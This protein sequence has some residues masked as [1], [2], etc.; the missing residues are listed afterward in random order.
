MNTIPCS[1]GCA[2]G[3][4]RYQANSPPSFSFHCQC[5]Q[6]QRASGAGHASLFVVPADAVSLT[7]ELKFY[8]QIADDG[9]TVSRGFCPVCGSPVVGKTSGHPDI[10][11]F[12][13]ASLDDPALF[14]PEK[15]VWSAS[16]QPWDFI[17][18]DLPV[19]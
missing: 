13:A 6:C 7:G 10:L 14:K 9:S 15:V 17:D 16:G 12:T 8:D 1:G 5:R 4:V 11:L 18:P 2:C 19:S 3:A